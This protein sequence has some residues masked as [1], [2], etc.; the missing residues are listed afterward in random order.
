MS[1]E[2]PTPEATTETT[3]TA[4]QETP[5]ALRDA[6]ERGKQ[7]R[8]ENV[9]L[10]RENAFLKAGINVED[11]KLA[12]FYKGYEGDLTRDAILA[13]AQEAGFIAPPQQDPAAAAT[14]AAEQRVVA[15]S[16]GGQ[17]ESGSLQA[18]QAQMAEV[19]AQGG[20][21]GLAMALSQSGI[22]TS[23]EG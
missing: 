10:K 14:Q 23:F 3:E 5:Q 17:A 18:A 7:A 1:D 4:T 9:T 13:A 11:P 16:A 12:Y 19:F 20:A 22:P 6:A 21:Q 2:T 8:A 15:A